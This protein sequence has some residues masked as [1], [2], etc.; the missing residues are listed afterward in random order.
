[1]QVYK[2]SDLKF[3]TVL[4]TKV[5]NELT[6]YFDSSMKENILSNINNDI[7]FTVADSYGYQGFISLKEND[8]TLEIKGLG[9]MKNSQRQKLGQALIKASIDY[10]KVN[11]KKLISINIKDDSSKDINYLKT[12]RFLTKMGFKN[13]TILTTD[14][15]LNPT[16]VMVYII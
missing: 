9:V 14:T 10:A 3:K 13:V 2:V 7:Y 12:R 11:N 6:E 8:D 1:M 16:L 4:T 5:L 15:F